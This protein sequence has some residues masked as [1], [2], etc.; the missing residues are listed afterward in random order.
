MAGTRE[1]G[2]DWRRLW[3]EAWSVPP[4]DKRDNWLAAEREIA[5]E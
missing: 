1:I 2:A 5:T 3:R 4:P